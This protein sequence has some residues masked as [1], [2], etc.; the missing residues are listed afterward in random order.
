[1]NAD[2]YWMG[3]SGALY[4]FWLVH[5]CR[6][7]AL[8]SEAGVYMFVRPVVV[9]GWLPVYVG[10]ADDMSNRLPTHE[11]WSEAAKLG[12]TRVMAH[13]EPYKATR[14]GEER[15][16]I[17]FWDPELNTH[18]RS[19]QTGMLAGVLASRRGLLR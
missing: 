5:D 14:E 1:M 12:A 6:A 8:K 3:K 9:G 10:I 18:H 7:H 19:L 16:L 4:P 15:D 11:R 13:T 17:R 2:W